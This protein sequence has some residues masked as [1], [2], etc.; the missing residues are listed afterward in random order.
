VATFRP[1][2]ENDSP[3][4][5]TRRTP[6]DDMDD[7]FDTPPGGIDEDDLLNS[8]GFQSVAPKPL[9]S[10]GGTVPVIAVPVPVIAVPVNVNDPRAVFYNTHS[11]SAAVEDF[12][13]EQEREAPRVSRRPYDPQL[14]KKSAEEGKAM[15]KA[16]MGRKVALIDKVENFIAPRMLGGK[17]NR[18]T[19]EAHKKHPK[20]YRYYE[21]L[22]ADLFNLKYDELIEDNGEEEARNMANSFCDEALPENIFACDTPDGTQHKNLKHPET[23]EF[24]CIGCRNRDGWSRSPKVKISIFCNFYGIPYA[25]KKFKEYDLRAIEFQKGESRTCQRLTEVAKELGLCAYVWISDPNLR[26]PLPVH[27]TGRKEEGRF[28]K[29]K[30][31]GRIS[32]EHK[33][34]Y[35]D[36]SHQTNEDECNGFT[37]GMPDKKGCCAPTCVPCHFAWINEKNIEFFDQQ[38]VGQFDPSEFDGEHDM[39]EIEDM[40]YRSD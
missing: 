26:R 16:I 14:S 23:N 35:T 2:S 18:G 37:P 4:R 39:S 30:T 17:Q 21:Y 9:S 11:G 12:G 31:E 7:N 33:N 38:T 6:M 24:N 15:G 29:L 40:I 19:K 34:V 32:D 5:G 13:D 1:F 27:S 36:V 25:D 20:Y 10:E 28:K 22:R 8:L 3:G